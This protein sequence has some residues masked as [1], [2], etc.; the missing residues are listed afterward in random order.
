MAYHITQY[1]TGSFGFVGSVPREL[2]YQGSAEDLE[3][4]W[5][6]GPGLARKI[7]ERNGRSFVTLTW[8]TREAA[9]SAADEY[10]AA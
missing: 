10:E 6:C 3:T 5:R 8:S 4:A 1:P 2:C 9:Q 7:A